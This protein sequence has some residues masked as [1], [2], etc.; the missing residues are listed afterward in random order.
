MDGDR[1]AAA[2]IVLSGVAPIPWQAADAEAA[3]IGRPASPETF[4]QAAEKAVSGAHPLVL[5]GYKVSL[6]RSLVSRALVDAT[7]D[8]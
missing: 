5:N 7:S 8:L 6:A 1:I 2:R 3:L 4:A